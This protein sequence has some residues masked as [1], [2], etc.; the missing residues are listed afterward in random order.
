MYSL[1]QLVLLH[2]QIGNFLKEMFMDDM[3]W[4][5]ALHIVLKA[6]VMFS[7]I[8]LFLRLTGKKGI[9]QL[10]I[11]EVAII[12]ALGSAAGDPMVDEKMAVVPSVIAFATILGFYRAI[13]FI[14]A[15]S[16]KA[17]RIIEGTPIYVVEDGMFSMDAKEAHTFAKDEFFAEMREAGISQVGQV[18]TAI[19][20]PNG[21]VSFFYY[22]DNEVLFGL[23]IL[24]RD[25]EKKT[26]EIHTKAHYACSNCG[27]TTLLE[28]TVPC[29]RCQ[30]SIWV[31]ASDEKRVG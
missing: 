21:K 19:L 2:T 9:R 1:A 5:F 10:S 15:K 30:H 14:A 3:N 23:P 31:V 6:L 25:Y 24:P 8:L 12:I 27:F 26:T 22:P 7:I 29:D 4:Q 16:S 13:T 20:E 11:F 18:K 17:E 28:E